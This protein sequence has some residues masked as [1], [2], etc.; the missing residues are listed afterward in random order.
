MRALVL[1]LGVAG[2]ILGACQRQPPM[3]AE[4]AAQAADKP[5]PMLA[6]VTPQ[7]PPTAPAQ[8]FVGDMAA[9][10]AFEIAAAQAAQQKAHLPSVRAYADMMVHDHTEATKKL[11]KAVAEAGQPLTLAA[12]PNAVQQAELSRLAGLAPKDFDKAYLE[13]Q[14][15]AHRQALTS[16]QAYG[17]NGDVPSLKAFAAEASGTVQGHLTHAKSLAEQVP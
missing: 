2:A 4:A 5:K 10:D 1:I 8:A 3:G 7:P 13:G 15:T 11:Q 6:A 17:Q 9:A 12:A 16:L 14:V